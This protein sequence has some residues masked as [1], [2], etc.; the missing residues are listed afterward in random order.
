MKI[1]KQELKQIIQEEFENVKSEGFL[2]KMLGRDDGLEKY[3]KKIE[4]YKKI[5]DDSSGYA[6]A[7]G[8]RKIETSVMMAIEELLKNIK[9]DQ[10]RSGVEELVVGSLGQQ[11]LL[12]R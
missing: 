5:I 10:L 3:R 8:Q 1:T 11:F 9:D 6:D 12:R 2:S 4:S 7:A